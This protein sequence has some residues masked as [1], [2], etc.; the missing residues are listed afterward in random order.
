[1]KKEFH[2]RN[3]FFLLLVAYMMRNM[4]LLNTSYILSAPTL[5]VE[6]AVI[7]LALTKKDVIF[8]LV[9]SK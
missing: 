6:N 5:S 4:I 3:C 2:S 9:S 1:M 8:H 7:S